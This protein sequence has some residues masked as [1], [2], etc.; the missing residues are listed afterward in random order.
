MASTRKMEAKRKAKKSKPKK[1]KSKRPA[2]KKA[3][4]KSA[5]KQAS[6]PLDGTTRATAAALAPARPKNDQE[7]RSLIEGIGA[8]SLHDEDIAVTLKHLN[9]VVAFRRAVGQP[10][11][12]SRRALT[13]KCYLKSAGDPIVSIYEGPYH[14]GSMS[15]ESAIALGIP[16]CGS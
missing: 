16:R 11:A 3:V 12:T 10:G 4:K 13:G 5:A 2:P 15:E 1:S 8:P 6:V 7:M 14:V 9:S